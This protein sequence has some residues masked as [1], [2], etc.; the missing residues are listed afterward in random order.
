MIK[1]I[2]IENK[3]QEIEIL[4]HKIG[5][6]QSVLKDWTAKLNLKNNLIKELNKQELRLED[7]KTMR[8]LFTGNGFVNYISTIR[9]QELVNYANLRFHKLTKNR[10]SLI[11]N[12]NNTFSI[13]DYLNDGKKRNMKTLSGGQQF[14]V[15]LSL[16]LALAGV[17]QKQT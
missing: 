16:A 15:S 1:Q 4:Q 3:K 9:L 5:G 11:L 10:L 7:L 8:S 2:E 17:V 12:P 14:Q 13:L 6:L